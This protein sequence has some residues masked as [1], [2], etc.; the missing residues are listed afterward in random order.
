MSNYG[1]K[2][3]ETI[4]K[5]ESRE[6]VNLA[7]M[8][9]T[10]KLFKANEKSLVHGSHHLCIDGLSL[11]SHVAV[12]ETDLQGQMKSFGDKVVSQIDGIEKDK[13]VH[14]QAQ[15][16]I[17]KNMRMLHCGTFDDAI[18]TGKR[19]DWL[20]YDSCGFAMTGE[21]TDDSGITQF[22]NACKNNLKDQAVAFFTCMVFPARSITAEEQYEI[23][24]GKRIKDVPYDLMVQAYQKHI[25]DRLNNQYEVAVTLIYPS[26]STVPFVMIGLTKNWYLEPKYINHVEKTSYRDVKTDLSWERYVLHANQMVS[27]MKALIESPFVS[28][29]KVEDEFLRIAP[30]LHNRTLSYYANQP[31]GLKKTLEDLL[32][33]MNHEEPKVVTPRENKPIQID[34]EKVCEQRAN[35]MS[36]EAIAEDLGRYKSYGY[37]M[38]TQ[39]NI[40]LEADGRPDPFKKKKANVNAGKKAAATRKRNLKKKEKVLARLQEIQDKM[41]EERIPAIK[42]LKKRSKIDQ[43]TTKPF[44]VE[45]A[46]CKE[47]HDLRLKG[48]TYQEISDKLDVKR[49]SVCYYIKRYKEEVLTKEVKVSSIK[50]KRGSSKSQEEIAKKRKLCYDLRQDGLTLAQIFAKTGIP[51]GSITGLALKHKE[52]IAECPLTLALK[53]YD[54]LTEEVVVRAFC[55]WSAHEARQLKRKACWELRQDGLTYNQIAVEMDIPQGTAFEYVRNWTEYLEVGV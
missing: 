24:T 35:L 48:L 17:P 27:N 32:A 18:S 41:Q 40:I 4:G 42:A 14:S 51:T 44:T 1:S 16:V 54:I 15:E 29:K 20:W 31:K 7:V 13:K 36:W 50:V 10:Q 33:I 19:Y 43:R 26:K 23:L 55:S 38:R 11:P 2:N 37:T 39:F 49:G 46:L 30:D 21:V 34:F 12:Q 28:T 52:S 53:E 3:A 22:V 8:R 5:E 47:C 45:I 6:V 9:L 25:M